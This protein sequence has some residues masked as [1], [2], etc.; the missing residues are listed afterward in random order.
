MI[1]VLASMII[2][3]KFDVI[4]DIPL[5]SRPK[6]EDTQGGG[7]AMGGT[8]KRLLCDLLQTSDNEQRQLQT[9]RA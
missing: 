6:A 4:R 1:M 8:C 3:L 7:N 2:E 5:V 9:S